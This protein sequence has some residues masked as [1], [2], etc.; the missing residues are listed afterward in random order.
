MSMGRRARK[1]RI[2]SGHREIGEHIVEIQ[3]GV[4]KTILFQSRYF[5]ILALL[6]MWQKTWI[7]SKM[8]HY[9]GKSMYHHHL[10]RVHTSTKNTTLRRKHH[11]TLARSPQQNGETLFLMNIA[12]RTICVRRPRA[13]LGECVRAWLYLV[14]LQQGLG[15][16]DVLGQLIRGHECH[17]AVD[18]GHEVSER[19]H[20]HTQTRL[21]YWL[22]S[23]EQ[24]TVCKA[25]WGIRTNNRQILWII[26]I[27]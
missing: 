8:L 19:E 22:P 23:T 16:S 27:M 26:H 10:Q 20:T 13:D 12:I 6:V 4:T 14:P 9:M 11:Q 3:W 17:H 2:V 18:P 1:L 15:T 24:A 25:T 7:L 5:A 21:N